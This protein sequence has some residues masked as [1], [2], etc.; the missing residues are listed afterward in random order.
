[1][2]QITKSDL[3]LLPTT[4]PAKGQMVAEYVSP[5]ARLHT[6]VIDVNTRC[7]PTLEHLMTAAGATKISPW[8]AHMR[9]FVDEQTPDMGEGGPP[10]VDAEIWGGSGGLAEQRRRGQNIRY[11]NG[12]VITPTKTLINGGPSPGPWG[13]KTQAIISLYSLLPSSLGLARPYRPPQPVS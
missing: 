2:T 3:Y 5:D 13:E 1:M 11:H 10:I 9:V 4:F 12:S 7:P 6:F 8:P